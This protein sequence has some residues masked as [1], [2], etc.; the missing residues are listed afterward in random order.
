M[1]QHNHS[2]DAGGEE[3]PFMQRLLDNP[4]QLLALGVAF[5]IVIYMVW[6]LIEAVTIP[7]AP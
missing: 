3:V 6:G 7:L 1:T 4:F 5:P 2:G